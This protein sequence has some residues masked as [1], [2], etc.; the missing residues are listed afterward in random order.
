VY[1]AHRSCRS[2]IGR[3]HQPARLA[4]ARRC[5]RSKV[6]IEAAGSSVSSPSVDPLGRRRAGYRSLPSLAVARVGTHFIFAFGAPRC[7]A[8][9]SP[10]PSGRRRLRAASGCFIPSVPGSGRR[11]TAEDSPMS[12]T[13]ATTQ[14]IQTTK[15]GPLPKAAPLAQGGNQLRERA[16]ADQPAFPF[17]STIQRH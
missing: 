4:A 2:S 14:E 6:A 1:R 8:V 12:N 11:A 16:A 3:G 15:R 17:F 13:P 5:T 9:S 7:T 10:G